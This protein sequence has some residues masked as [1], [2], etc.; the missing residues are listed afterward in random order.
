M[1][2]KK[3]TA[4]KPLCQEGAH[5]TIESM[6]S[7]MFHRADD[8]AS[9]IFSALVFV[10]LVLALL[11]IGSIITEP[12]NIWVVVLA[13]AVGVLGIFTIHLASEWERVVVLRL[14]KFSRVVG[15]GIYLTVPF[16]EHA[17][18]HADQR[19]M[20]TCFS[21][22]ETLTADFVPVNVDAALFWM[23]QDAKMACIEVE[24]YY[25]ATSMAAQTALRDAIGRKELT[26]VTTH[27]KQLDAELQ[28][29]IDEKT[30]NWG[31]SV[32]AVEIRDIVIPKELQ[33]AMAAA[34]T[35]DRQRDARVVLAEIEK[36]IASMLIEATDLYEGHDKA[37]ELRTMHLLNEGVKQGSGTLVVP[38]A[39][40][41]GFKPENTSSGRQ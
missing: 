27:R 40:S 31:V 16:V 17:S 34:A 26:A 23:V 35:A 33:E 39:Y 12:I 10:V 4:G 24:N 19:I 20:L 11:A 5:P 36:D 1:P 18:L 22:E 29:S 32:I 9:K 3:R 37:F 28:R 15:P 2:I 8:N 30:N 13:F 38:S 6:N 21:T 7:P 41:E 25:N 14:G